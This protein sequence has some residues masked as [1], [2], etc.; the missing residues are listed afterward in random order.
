MNNDGYFQVSGPLPAPPV[1]TRSS[2]VRFELVEDPL[3]VTSVPN[4]EVLVDPPPV[5]AVTAPAQGA[6][7][8]SISANPLITWNKAFGSANR[9][10]HIELADFARDTLLTC[11]VDDSADKSESLRP[12]CEPGLSKAQRRPLD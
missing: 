1:F 5:P 2:Q 10:I 9:T 7:T 12:L 11:E 3:Q 4:L 8:F 6:T